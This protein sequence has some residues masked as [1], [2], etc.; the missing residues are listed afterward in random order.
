M[1][2]AIAFP[3]LFLAGCNV[4][5]DDGNGTTTVS[6]DQNEAANAAGA[7]VNEAQDI[8]GAIANDVKEGADKVGNTIE[9][10]DAD[11]HSEHSE[12][13]HNAS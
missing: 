6:F 7:V 10:H 13:N 12:M 1:R 3:L 5:K 9:K 2:I 8:G 4:S 11:N